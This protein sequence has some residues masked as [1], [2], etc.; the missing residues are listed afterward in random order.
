MPDTAPPADGA[1]LTSSYL[2]T[3]LREQVIRTVTSSTRPTGVE[4]AWIFETDTE[5]YLSYD[6]AG[7]GGWI[8]QDEP[9]QAWTPAFSNTT[10]GNG[11]KVGTS[12]RSGGWVDF[13]AIFTLGSTSAMGTTPALTLPYAA[14]GIHAG[15]LKVMAFDAAPSYAPGTHTAVAA[16]GTTCDL[17]VLAANSTYL[18]NGTITSTTPFTWATG[19]ILAVSGRYQMN[20]RYL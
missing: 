19:D 12:R 9:I 8:I 2:Q 7:G 20:T 4:G 5:R 18:L 11:T 13:T 15:A 10:T 6:T 16:A 17:M 14:K 3:M 1:A